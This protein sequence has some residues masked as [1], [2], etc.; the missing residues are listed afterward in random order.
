MRSLIRKASTGG[1]FWTLGNSWLATGAKTITR[2]RE[3]NLDRQAVRASAGSAKAE[4]G[5]QFDAINTHAHC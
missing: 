4:Y 5:L 2:Y 1:S 3:E